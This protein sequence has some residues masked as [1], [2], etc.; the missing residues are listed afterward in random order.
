M[1]M[2]RCCQRQTLAGLVQLSLTVTLALREALSYCNVGVVNGD[3]AREA[4]TKRPG[5]EVV[6]EQ[7]AM[8]TMCN[9]T[10]ERISGRDCAHTGRK[11]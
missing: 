4:K 3:G 6:P 5:D 2:T 7:E 10:H 1:K 11:R 9:C 8:G